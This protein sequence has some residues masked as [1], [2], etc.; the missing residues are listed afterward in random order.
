MGKF[1]FADWFETHH[2]E[3]GFVGLMLFMALILCH[4]AE[5]DPIDGS[6][7]NAL[8]LILFYVILTQIRLY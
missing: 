5:K 6:I 4:G 2:R 3:V 8:G 1:A 7:F